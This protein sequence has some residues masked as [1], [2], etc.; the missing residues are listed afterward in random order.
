VQAAGRALGLLGL[1]SVAVAAPEVV[2]RV[3]VVA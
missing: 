3:V 1:G 2:V